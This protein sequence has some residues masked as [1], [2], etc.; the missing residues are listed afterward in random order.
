MLDAVWDEVAERGYTEL[1]YEAVA[2]RAGTS[3]SVVYR[4]WPTKRE[5]VLAAIAHRGAARSP[6]EAADTG[7]LRGDLLAV[8]R[9]FNARRA[10][11]M[12]LF[13]TRLGPL[14]Q[15][16]GV[17][18]SVT[19]DY[20]LGERSSLMEVI[21]ERALARGEADPARLTPRAQRAAMDL[22]RHDV[23]ME[24]GPVPDQDIVEIVDDVVMPLFTGRAPEP[25]SAG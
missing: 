25:R 10:A 21:V 11:V 24:L 19:R 7:G 5:L 3:R 2:A 22:L 17:S 23:L 9:D 18:P 12:V 1:T 13:G 8:L 14:Y 6:L 4:R 16:G 20:W 15:E